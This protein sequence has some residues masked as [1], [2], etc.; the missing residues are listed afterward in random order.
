MDT[1]GSRG[2]AE[3]DCGKAVRKDYKEGKHADIEQGLAVEMEK[4]MGEMVS[5]RLVRNGTGSTRE[6]DP[7]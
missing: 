1:H 3:R 6:Q 4:G 2:A 5:V 7:Q